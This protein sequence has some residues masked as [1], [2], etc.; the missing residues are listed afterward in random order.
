MLYCPLVRT[1]FDN[2]LTYAIKNIINKFILVTNFISSKNFENSLFCLKSLLLVYIFLW[3]ND[4][5]FSIRSKIVSQKVIFII[6][7]YV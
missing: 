3:M 2:Y 7:K 1:P 4:F 6:E 5:K